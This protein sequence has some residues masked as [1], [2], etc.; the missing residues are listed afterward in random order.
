MM[1]AINN[2]KKMNESNLLGKFPFSHIWANGASKWAKNDPKRGFILFFDKT[3]HLILL[4]IVE[5]ERLLHGF[6]AQAP[7]LTKS[8]FLGDCPK[9]SSPIRLHDSYKRFF[10]EERVQ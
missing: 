9:C 1:L 3:C 10:L 7:Y 6:I 4:K 8:C 2:F 5:D